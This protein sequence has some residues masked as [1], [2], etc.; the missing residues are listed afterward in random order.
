MIFRIF[1]R[2][3]E[4]SGYCASS[5]KAAKKNNGVGCRIS[6][7]Q[8]LKKSVKSFKRPC[9]SW[10]KASIRLRYICLKTTKS[11]FSAVRPQTK[12][13]QLPASVF[14]LTEV[15]VPPKTEMECQTEISYYQR[16][17]QIM[18]IEKVLFNWKHQ[19]I[20]SWNFFLK[21][22]T[23]LKP[24]TVSWK[25]PSKCSALGKIKLRS[26]HDYLEEK[27]QSA[28]K[29]PKNNVFIKNLSPVQDSKSNSLRKICYMLKLLLLLPL[30]IEVN[31][32]FLRCAKDVGSS[33]VLHQVFCACYFGFVRFFSAIFLMFPKVPPVNC[34]FYFATEWM[35]KK[36]QRVPR[37]ANSV[38]LS[39]FLIRVL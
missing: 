26:F 7:W 21:K 15:R 5:D 36:S 20:I 32:D 8:D 14:R 39:F 31:R 19:R 24:N 11:T 27:N 33:L 25:R 29:I 17:G 28:E 13:R 6:G 3:V 1:S 34:F 16:K 4:C 37:R 12:I 2:K 30:G 23:M 18:R 22:R 9:E 35:F 10:Q 38:Q